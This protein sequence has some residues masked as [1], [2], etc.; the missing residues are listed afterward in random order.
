[1]T[2]LPDRLPGIQL[3]VV[4][5]EEASVV[6]LP[7]QILPVPVTF[8]DGGAVTVTAMVLVPE[9]PLVVPVTV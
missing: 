2:G 6:L 5:P 3:Y 7:E 4:A 9:H 1:M 8:T